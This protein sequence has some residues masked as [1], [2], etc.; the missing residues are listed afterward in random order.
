MALN[1]FTTQNVYRTPERQSSRF[2]RSNAGILFYGSIFRIVWTASR[3][4]KRGRYRAEEWVSSSLDTVR[5][6]ERVG[7]RFELQNLS[8]IQKVDAPCVFISNHMSI[9]ETFVFPCLI[10]PHRAVTF[11]I[12]E[13]LVSYPFFGHVMQ[14]RNPIVVNRENP[15]EDLKTV[16]SE[17]DTRL[18]NG[19]SVVIFPQTTR[20]V[21]F[22]PTKFNSLGVKLARRAGAPVIPV[23]L[24]TDA[25]GLGRRFKDF[26]KI[27]PEKTVRICF[28]E[29]M[30]IT[31]P[32]KEEHQ[33][34]TEFIAAK[35][36]EW[37]RQ[38]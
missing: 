34:I 24:K 9:L 7:G 36:D 4:A 23:A 12:K 38:Q 11:V 20:S 19:I 22:D 28:G 16:L 35:L 25:W 26:G 33:W 10:R 18:K 17:G 5:A 1:A 13:S 6:L 27:C 31:G 2:V 14:S 37:A 21:I 29:P 3:L 8:V 15:R 30:K 32:G